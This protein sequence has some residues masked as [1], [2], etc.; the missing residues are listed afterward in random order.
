[1][2]IQPIA[3]QTN[4]INNPD[5]NNRVLTNKLVNKILINN[6]TK[7]TTN[8]ERTLQQHNHTFNKM[9]ISVVDNY[10]STIDQ[11]TALR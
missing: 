8:A 10:D 6:K 11:E 2:N 1:M 3:Q 7:A 9:S 4:K 5:A